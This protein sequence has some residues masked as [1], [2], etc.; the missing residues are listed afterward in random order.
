MAQTSSIRDPFHRILGVMA[1]LVFTAAWALPFASTPNAGAVAMAAPEAS[2][3]AV[4][5]TR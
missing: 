3:M 2:V 1:V 5:T 4:G